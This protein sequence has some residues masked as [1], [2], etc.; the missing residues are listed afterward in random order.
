M[1]VVTECPGVQAILVPRATWSDPAAF[2]AAAR[3]LADLFKEDFHKYRRGRVRR[4]GLPGRRRITMSK[5]NTLPGPRRK[6]ASLPATQDVRTGVTV[7]AL[8]QAFSTT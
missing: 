2:D 8:K 6:A 3:K 1:D 7:E 5:M 4:S